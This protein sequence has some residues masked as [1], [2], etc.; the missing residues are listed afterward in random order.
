MSTAGANLHKPR[1]IKALEWLLSNADT[2][3]ALALAVVFGVLGTVGGAGDDVVRGV[4]LLVLGLIAST[5]IRL[6]SAR[7][8]T[9]AQI[10]GVQASLTALGAD[11]AALESGTPWRVIDSELTWDMQTRDFAKF[12]KARKLHFYRNEVMSLHDWFG[13]DGTSANE[14]SSPGTF[15]S[16][17]KFRIGDKEYSLIS[18][19]SF[20]KRGDDLNLV[21]TRDLHDSFPAEQNENVNIAVLEETARAQLKVI[22]PANKRPT[23]VWL[24]GNQM[25]YKE[26]DIKALETEPDGRDS[27]TYELRGPKVGEDVYIFWNW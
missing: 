5:L 9:K 6:R 26:I 2:A 8:E 17:P 18:F 19:P 11:V 24:S 7:E 15:L 22:W 1:V 10:N 23:K 12:T 20:Y 14:T 21:I 4:T 27:F 3:V 16:Q 25:A 13:A